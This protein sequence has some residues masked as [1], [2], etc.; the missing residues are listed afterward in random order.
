MTD[1]YL[2]AHKVRGEPTFDIAERMVC[3]ECQGDGNLSDGVIGI[4]GDDGMIPCAECDATGFWWIIPT[5]GHRAYPYWHLPM[6]VT[7][8]DGRYLL[9][10]G[11]TI[12]DGIPEM[13]PSLPDHYPTRQA[14]KDNPS[15]GK[16]LLAALGLLP[17]VIR[18]L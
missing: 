17:K 13:P 1:L 3:S 6:P 11:Q 8:H 4:S 14:P 18:R 12:Y 15:S 7:Y 16:S 2:I 5:S 10:M 9:A